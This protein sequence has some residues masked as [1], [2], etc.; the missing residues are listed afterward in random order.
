MATARFYRADNNPEGASFPGV[1]LRDIEKDEWERYP[2]WLQASVD[3]STF[4]QKTNPHPVSRSQAKTEPS[5]PEPN[6][7]GSQ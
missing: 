7:D 5:Q 3:A 4:Y 6:E 1:P 2:E